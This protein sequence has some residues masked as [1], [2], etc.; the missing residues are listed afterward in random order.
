[1]QRTSCR[2]C[3]K[4]DDAASNAAAANANANA[5]NHH[6]QSPQAITIGNDHKQSQQNT[7]CNHQGQHHKQSPHTVTTCDHHK[8][9]HRQ[10]WY[11]IA[12]YVRRQSP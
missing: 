1:M 3:W 10:S 11:R 7:I 6:R 8:S 4:P 9:E 5:N 12:L 2:H